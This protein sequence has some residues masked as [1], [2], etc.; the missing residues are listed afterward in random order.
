[1]DIRADLNLMLK[2]EQFG[3]ARATLRRVK[4]KFS[5]Y[6]RYDE[7]IKKKLSA[8]PMARF[9]TGCDESQYDD[10]GYNVSHPGPAMPASDGVSVRAF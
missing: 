2:N 5:E 6:N 7:A 1:M 10:S 4:G 8:V 3:M 9:G